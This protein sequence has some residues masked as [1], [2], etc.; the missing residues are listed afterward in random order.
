MEINTTISA[1]L[2]ALRGD[3]P[4]AADILK[5]DLSDE[6]QPWMHALDVKLLPKF[7]PDFP[8]VVAICGGGSAGK[9]TLFNSLIGRALSP[10][11]GRAG[12]NRRVL[13]ALQEPHLHQKALFATLAHVFGATLSPL[14][15]PDQLTTPGHPVYCLSSDGPSHVV[16]LDTPDIDTG[17]RG[18]Y[19][20]REL[21]RQSLE[22]A[23]AFIYIFTNATYNNRDN[24][25]FIARLFT[26]L[27]TRPC[28][29]VYRVYPS[30]SDEEVREHALTTATNIYGEDYERHVMGIFRADD[31]NRVAAGQLPMTLRSLQGGG[32]DL[33]AA[34]AAMDAGRLRRQLMHSMLVDAATQAG[35]MVQTVCNGQTWLARYIG[36]LESAQRVSVQQALSH[37]PLDRVLRHFA[38]TWVATDPL[39]IK[40]MRRTGQV[41]EWPFRLVAAGVGIARGTREAPSRKPGGAEDS[42]DLM[43]F[44]LLQA[45]NQLYQTTMDDRILSENVY[46]DA[47]PAVRAIQEQ[48]RRK[49]WKAVLIHIQ[50]QKEKLLSWS[51]GL[52][53]DLAQLA[54]T[55]RGR[56]GLFGQIRQ[57]F[58]A[59][60]NVIPTTV[61]ITYILS[62]GDPVGAVGLKIKLTGLLGLHDLYALIAI[63]A[64]AGMKKA[65]QRQLQQ[66]LTPLARTWL[67]HKLTAV[68]ALFEEQI[69]GD[70]LATARSANRQAVE[71]LNR[72]TQHLAVL[73]EAAA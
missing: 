22:S 21:A 15:N 49:D 43:A 70:V 16:L 73:K 41:V 42:A 18:T 59:L 53:K 64:T 37:F 36:A 28:F 65:D 5:L 34:L 7:Q 51:E 56:M 52:Q 4:A 44:D 66:M 10:T 11:G 30:F 40:L 23:D 68:Q 13:L 47:H 62:T 67:A 33:K 1:A 12:L 20:N 3:L 63:P 71:R 57:T 72:I 17:A 46:I 55:L 2:E 14:Q 25:D 26:G 38:E 32:Q 19:A 50:R 9:S 6:L 58:A 45:A 27:G 39:H 24:T 29:L 54:G 8:L 61:A 60:L 35:D 31:D 69:T 48:L